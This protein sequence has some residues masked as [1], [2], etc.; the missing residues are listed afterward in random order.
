MVMHNNEACLQMRVGRRF[1]GDGLGSWSPGFFPLSL[2][3]VDQH[4]LSVH[5]IAI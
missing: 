4:V 5:E 1:L 2:L 3:L